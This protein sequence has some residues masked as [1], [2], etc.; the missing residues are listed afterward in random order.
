[1]RR[2][3]RLL[4]APVVLAQ[5]LFF[6]YIAQ[7]RFVDGDEGFYLLAS[8]L[9]LIHKTPYL[10]FSYVQAPLLL[11][12]YAAWMKLTAVSWVSARSFSAVLTTLLGTLLYVEICHQTRRWLVGLAAAVLRRMTRD[13]VTR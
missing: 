4:L 5:G 6:L 12:A 10:D 13:G 1:M 11:Y 7:H 8:R 3:S 9:V 2:G